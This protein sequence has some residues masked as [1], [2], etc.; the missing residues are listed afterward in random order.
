MPIYWGAYKADHLICT[1]FAIILIFFLSSSNIKRRFITTHLIFYSLFF[2]IFVLF[3]SAVFSEIIEYSLYRF[4][5]I[6][7]YALVTVTLPLLLPGF[8]SSFSR[9][10]LL[11][12]LSAAVVLW[13]SYLFLGLSPW[14]RMTMPT[15][16]SS[17]LVYFPRG[18]GT[19]ADPNTLGVGIMLSLVFGFSFLGLRKV[20]NVFLFLFIFSAALLTLSRTALLG[21]LGGWIVAVV[22]CYIPEFVRKSSLRKVVD[23]FKRLSLVLFLSSI[24]VYFFLLDFLSLFLNRVNIGVHIHEGTSYERLRRMKYAFSK[25]QNSDDNFLLGIGFDMVIKDT[26]PHNIYITA[27]HDSGALGLIGLLLLIAAAFIDICKM[28]SSQLK[29]YAMWLLFIIVFAGMTYWHT[30]NFWY[31]FMFIIIL[32]ISDCQEHGSCNSFYDISKIRI[33]W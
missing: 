4:C 12:A 10:V 3:L 13:L 22:F 19:S 2:Y 31:A 18:W 21:F 20:F 32:I 29:F 8:S 30:K 25:W 11:L 7:G 15:L 6:G 17:G 33:K 1:L 5:V 28:K 14:G 16:T 9:M 26:D 23:L 27:L 24:A